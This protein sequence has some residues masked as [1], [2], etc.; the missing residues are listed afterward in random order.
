MMA[1]EIKRLI[2]MEKKTEAERVLMPLKVKAHW[3]TANRD[4]V[5]REIPCT[6]GPVTAA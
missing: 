2:P 3:M 1:R 4:Q 5:V 6:D